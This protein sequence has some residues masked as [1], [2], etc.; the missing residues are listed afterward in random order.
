MF[1]VTAVNHRDYPFFAAVIATAA[2][3]R[4]FRCSG[5]FI[6][7]QWVITAA[8]CLD[9]GDSRRYSVAPNLTDWEQERVEDRINSTGRFMYPVYSA[10][11]YDDYNFDEIGLLQLPEVEG[12]RVI[13]L[14]KMGEDIEFIDRNGSMLLDILASGMTIAQVS[15]DE[16]GFVLKRT[17]KR[18]EQ[19]HCY[20]HS[21]AGVYT[22]NLPHHVCVTSYPSHGALLC[23]ADSGGPAVFR[24]R[25]TVALAAVISAVPYSCRRFSSKLFRSKLFGNL[26]R[27]TGHISW[28]LHTIDRYTEHHEM[29]EM[30]DHWMA[31]VRIISSNY[32]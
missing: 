10:Q 21:D 5:A 30:M 27:I 1:N 18:L 31:D 3:R 32:P 13:S 2:G 14:P 15:T 9:Y 23:E 24:S 17:G 6:S 22:P 8:H 7:R 28:I 29:V 4:D 12:A 20:Q 19:S 25:G 26:I 11:D 16:K